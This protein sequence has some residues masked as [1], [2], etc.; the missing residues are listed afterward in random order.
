MMSNIL[1]AFALLLMPQQQPAQALTK[2]DSVEMLIPKLDGFKK[3]DTMR[4][5]A[6]QYRFTNTR[7]AIDIN[8]QAL[9][10]ARDKEIEYNKAKIYIELGVEH[11]VL[12]E[13]DLANAHY[14][15]ALMLSQTTTTCWVLFILTRAYC[16]LS[17]SRSTKRLSGN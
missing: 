1:L 3:L 13:H 5:L 17:K 6:K 2:T 11:T 12:S 16:S 8:R 10:I 4:W 14:D 7:K 9:A 15:T